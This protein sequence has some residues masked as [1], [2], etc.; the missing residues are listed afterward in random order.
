MTA[1]TVP[2]RG[3]GIV[4]RDALPWP[5][6]LQVVRTAEETGYAAVFVPEIEAREAFGTLAGFGAATERLFLGTG[7]VTIQS[8]TPTTAAMAAAT[9]HEQTGGRFVLGIGAGS[10]RGAAGL[11]PAA[12]H[13]RPLA[14]TEEY[15]QIVRRALAGERVASEAFGVT[16]FRLRLS[17]SGDPGP[18]DVW[19]AALG[20]RMLTL[21]GRVADGVL[22]NWCT[23]ERVASARRTIAEAAEA[24]GR[25]PA[26]VTVAVYVRA[27]L[28]AE[29]DSA[30]PSL[31]AMTGLY[32]SIPGIPSADEGHGFR[33]R[34]RGRSRSARRGPAGRRSRFPGA[35]PHRH[36][37][38]GRGPRSGSA[39]TE[40][41]API[42]SCAIRS[43]AGHD[44]LTSVMGTIL[45]AAPTPAVE[46]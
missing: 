25:D 8:R 5:D 43:V 3:T 46:P 14:L 4:L 19:L 12:A 40:R 23:P 31:R 34:G 10:G 17:F 7:V 2:E 21:A 29:D 1:M 18:P 37:W 28:D 41:P 26:A 22:L 33:R 30:L 11:R 36:G 9:V 38:A 44:P 24:A 42:W 39:P 32:A 6:A 16:G 20:D 45:A 15:T 27:A 13:L 35:G